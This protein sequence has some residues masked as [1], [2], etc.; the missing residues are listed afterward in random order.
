MSSWSGQGDP[1][2]PASWLGPFN[3]ARSDT[4]A[5]AGGPR[6]LL[7]AQETRAGTDA[8]MV[9]RKFGQRTSAAPARSPAARPA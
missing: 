1:N 6:G 2:N 9:V 5:L 4:Y 3:F 7:I 8:R